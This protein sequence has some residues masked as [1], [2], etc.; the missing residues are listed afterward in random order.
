MKSLINN[1]LLN[2]FCTNVKAHNGGERS[3][4]GKACDTNNDEDIIS[5]KDRKNKEIRRLKEEIKKL[6]SQI[7]MLENEINSLE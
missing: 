7:E 6:K 4:L 5:K 1:L 3:D 2:P